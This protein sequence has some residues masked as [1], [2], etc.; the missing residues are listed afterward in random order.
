[1][2][3]TL[4]EIN[5]F[6][7][8]SCRGF[9]AESWQLEPRGFKYDRRWMLVDDEGMFMTQREFPRM[10]LIEVYARENHLRVQAPNMQPLI[11]PFE[12]LSDKHIPVVVWDD[13]VEAVAV[14]DA[15]AEWF[16]EF[17]KVS[18]ALVVMTE[19]SIRPVDRQ[20]AI[21]NDV[22]SFADGYPLLLL[23]EATLAVLNSRLANPIPMK[24]FRPNLV[25]KGCEPHAEDAWKEIQIGDVKFHV[26]KPCAR[27]T[28]PTVDIESGVKG[29]E[30]LRTLSMYRT[31]DNKVLFGQ[32]LI[33]ADNGVVHV[34]DDVRILQTK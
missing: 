12:L 11:V 20:F 25:V 15:A 21:N 27:C 29:V 34:G 7:I 4:S 24:R 9:S 3:I 32:N 6:P 1:M 22:V 5:I 17:L 28:I 2:S 30:P 16:S 33:H 10:S 8:K 13:G 23:S 19:R 26:V 31:T 14:G 18:C